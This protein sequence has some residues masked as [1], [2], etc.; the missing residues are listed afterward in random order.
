MSV[1][2]IVNRI[3]TERF[4]LSLSGVITIVSTIFL[5]WIAIPGITLNSHD[6]WP[7][8][9]AA[10]DIYGSVTALFSGLAFAG[11]ILTLILQNR[12]LR[13]QRLQLQQQGF[14]FRSAT[15]LNLISQEIAQ[16]QI[17]VDGTPITGSIAIKEVSKKISGRLNAHDFKALFGTLDNRFLVI[18]DLTHTH[19]ELIDRN[20]I[21]SSEEKLLNKKILRSLIGR[22]LSVILLGFLA[23]GLDHYEERARYILNA[24]ELKELLK[25]FVAPLII[26]ELLN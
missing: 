17:G 4:W 12:E 20:E 21:I 19:L 10:G 1:S 23:L 13:E 18:F 24:L 26:D 14:E 11:L 9:G 15:I 22:D 16:F 3:A 25:G 2:K 7:D 8:R 5:L 6:N